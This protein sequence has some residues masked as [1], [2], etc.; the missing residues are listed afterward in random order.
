MF[1]LLQTLQEKNITEL[2]VIFVNNLE[3]FILPV[4]E[5]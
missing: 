1:V 2:T 3:I 4:F 5:V